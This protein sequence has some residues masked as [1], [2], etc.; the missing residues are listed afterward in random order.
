M[1]HFL[2]RRIHRQPLLGRGDDGQA[3]RLQTR[4]QPSRLVP[5][6]IGEVVP[7]PGHLQRAGITST[8]GLEFRQ[9]IH[10]HRN[11]QSVPEGFRFRRKLDRLGAGIANLPAR[12]ADLPHKRALARGFECQHRPSGF[13][14]VPCPSARPRQADRRGSCHPTGQAGCPARGHSENQR[15]ER[16]AFTCRIRGRLRNPQTVGLSGTAQRRA[17]DSPRGAGLHPALSDQGRLQPGES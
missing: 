14:A 15:I 9:G 12:A 11:R 10:R 4:R 6:R 7:D 16:Y 3:G 1:W 17:G 2:H 13:A 5:V 8:V